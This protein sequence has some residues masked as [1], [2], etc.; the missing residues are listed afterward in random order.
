MLLYYLLQP[1][2][3]DS[4]KCTN[5]IVSERNDPWEKHK[6]IKTHYTHF[7]KKKNQCVRCSAPKQ[8]SQCWVAEKLLYTLQC[9]VLISTWGLCCLIFALVLM[10]AHCVPCVTVLWS[11]FTGSPPILLSPRVVA[12]GGP[13]G[14]GLSRGRP[15]ILTGTIRCLVQ[16]H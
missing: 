3:P 4:D 9:P 15:L 8:V 7:T 11:K 10:E 6:K 5:S 2:R 14:T 16:A 1:S 12:E 13:V